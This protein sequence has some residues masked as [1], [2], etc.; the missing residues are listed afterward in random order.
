MLISPEKRHFQDW[1]ST[2]INVFC[3][4]D[5]LSNN[6][7]KFS[8]D[9]WK[10]LS[11]LLSG[12]FVRVI[13][14]EIYTS[15]SQ[16]IA[17]G[18]VMRYLPTVLIQSGFEHSFVLLNNIYHGIGAILKKCSITRLK[19]VASNEKGRSYENRIFDLEN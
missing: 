15:H 9:L 5:G 11:N 12:R 16:V 17:L 13:F 6:W 14:F 10:N 19:W 7:N 1:S 2:K 8:L 3:S 4:S 18:N